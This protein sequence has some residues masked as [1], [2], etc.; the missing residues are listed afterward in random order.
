MCGAAAPENTAVNIPPSL[1]MK[2]I[3]GKGPDLRGKSAVHLKKVY[4]RIKNWPQLTGVVIQ[5]GLREFSPK[6]HELE[7]RGRAL[8]RIG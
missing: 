3:K 2:K 5:K 8:I 1:V 7:R 6:Y 4:R